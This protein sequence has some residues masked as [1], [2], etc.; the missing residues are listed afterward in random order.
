MTK[1][2]LTLDD[3]LPIKVNKTVKPKPAGA[4]SIP[5]MLAVFHNEWDALMLETHE[6]RKDLHATRQELS[7]ALYQHDAACRVIARLVKERDEA[8]AALADAQGAP[9]Q[10]RASAPGASKRPADDPA[11]ADVDDGK[12][13]K[14][15][16]PA[17]AV[18]AMA[19]KAK[20]L[21]K[22]R[23]KREISPSLT[24]ADGIAAFS[25]ATTAPCHPTK[26]KGIAA[27]A[28]NPSDGD[29]VATGGSDG[30]VALFDASKGKRASQLAGHKKRVR[31][32]AWAG[33]ALLSASADKTVRVWR[34]ETCAATMDGAHE[35]EIS[36]VS[37]HPTGAYAVSFGADGS[38]AFHDVGAAETLAVVRD[39]DAGSG[40]GYAAGGFHPDGLILATA[41][42][43][44]TVKVWDVKTQKSVAKMEG[45][46]GAVTSLSFSENGYYMATAAGDG[47]KLW[48]LRK[49]KNFKSL[50]AADARGVAF[51]HSGHYLAVVGGSEA[52]VCNVKAEWET[53]KVWETPK[54]AHA[55][56][57]APD[58]KA[59]YVGCADH[60]LRVYA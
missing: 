48:D 54:P 8:R 24:P 23:K 56:A 58:A 26:C 17:A 5:G 50:D 32:L 41:G 51:D 33:E 1:T 7:H 28:V 45:H 2:P 38:W 6:L 49:L 36:A 37:A 10:S 21:S 31:G 18:D 20:E 14:G 35:G 53:V 39:E 44:S 11:P 57:F 42:A 27:V 12:R 16:V 46:V 34:G 40:G 47:V 43:D 30:S 9:G 59:V 13:A 29:V 52:R 4:T 25:C 55:V 22:A 3:L 60:N 15:G 19:A